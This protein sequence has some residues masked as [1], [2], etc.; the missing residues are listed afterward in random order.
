[1]PLTDPWGPPASR[2]IRRR[3]TRTY[4]NP[5]IPILHSAFVQDCW[6]TGTGSPLCVLWSPDQAGSC[7]AEASER[8][9][10]LLLARHPERSPRQAAPAEAA[11]M[12]SEQSC[13]NPARSGAQLLL[14]ANSSG[15]RCFGADEGVAVSLA[16]VSGSCSCVAIAIAIASGG[17]Y[18]PSGF[19]AIDSRTVSGAPL[20]GPLVAG[21][22]AP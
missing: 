20:N 6:P 12:S 4:L 17:K 21:R 11:I 10:P 5:R 18:M 2:Q 14:P 15:S 13:N 9:Y 22:G 1:M 3:P 19:S 8:K 16:S 7:H